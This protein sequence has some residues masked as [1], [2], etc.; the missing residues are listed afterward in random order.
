MFVF[1]FSKFTIPS[2]EGIVSSTRELE[3]IASSSRTCSFQEFILFSA[4]TSAFS[5]NS[6][7]M[8]FFIFSVTFLLGFLFGVSII[9]VVSL[10][11]LF[12]VSELS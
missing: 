9:S 11:E 5:T 8:I 2:S 4:S 6:Q 7:F 12:V 10:R 3:L 1:G